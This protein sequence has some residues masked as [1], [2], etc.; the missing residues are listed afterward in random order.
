MLRKAIEMAFRISHL[1]Y[2]VSEYTR[3]NIYSSTTSS[4]DQ[5]IINPLSWQISDI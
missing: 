1:C 5:T 2:I 4:S 3:Y